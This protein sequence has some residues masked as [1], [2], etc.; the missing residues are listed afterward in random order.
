MEKCYP[1]LWLNTELFHTTHVVKC[2][3]LTLTFSSFKK[4]ESSSLSLRVNTL[5]FMRSLCVCVCVLGLCTDQSGEWRSRLSQGL[6]SHTDQVVHLSSSCCR[7]S[8][9][10]PGPSKTSRGP[11]PGQLTHPCVQTAGQRQQLLTC[12]EATGRD[13]SQTQPTCFP[14]TLGNSVLCFVHTGLFGETWQLI[15]GRTFTS[16]QIMQMADWCQIK[17]TRDQ[18]SQDDLR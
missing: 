5:R 7:H 1:W 12:G 16:L 10:G 17:N 3:Y 2:N 6:A 8:P 9:R 11:L 15:C 4:N 14:V 13:S 18:E